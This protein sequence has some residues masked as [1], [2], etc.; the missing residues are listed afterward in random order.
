MPLPVLVAETGMEPLPHTNTSE[1]VTLTREWGWHREPRLPKGTQTVH[2]VQVLVG[3]TTVT[4][5]ADHG[6]PFFIIWSLTSIK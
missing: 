2:S 6:S 3:S 4:V 5:T 1:A